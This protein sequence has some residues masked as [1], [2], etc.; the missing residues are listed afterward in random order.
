MSLL[1]VEVKNIVL[2][3]LHEVNSQ[4]NS[5]IIRQMTGASQWFWSQSKFSKIG[6]DFGS[7]ISKSFFE[8]FK[9][10]VI[11]QSDKPIYLCSACNKYPETFLHYK[12]CL[13]KYLFQEDFFF[14]Y[15]PY[16]SGT[17][18]SKAE[19]ERLSHWCKMLEKSGGSSWGFYNVENEHHNIERVESYSQYRWAIL[20]TSFCEF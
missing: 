2:T 8:T 7:F 3:C 15:K 12:K 16:M 6:V 19:W 13:S 9:K 17:E 10:R 4:K 1:A 18:K 11:Y 14:F 5:Q 20:T